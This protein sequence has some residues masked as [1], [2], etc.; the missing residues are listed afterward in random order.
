[1]H[2][3]FSVVL[4]TH[5]DVI[6]LPKSYHCQ[7]VCMHDPSAPAHCKTAQMCPACSK[8]C[9]HTAVGVARMV[10]ATHST[11][12]VGQLAPPMVGG[13]EH[14]KQQQSITAK[15]M[16][17]CTSHLSKGSTV[18]AAVTS[19]AAAAVGVASIIGSIRS[20]GRMYS[21][22]TTFS[23]GSQQQMT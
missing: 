7:N 20:V 8:P 19:A 9:L 12:L 13:P 23:K 5:H 6:T 15:R 11:V 1:M 18:M 4:R 17:L 3:Q 2:G 14:V 16:M 10:G 21:T 22:Q